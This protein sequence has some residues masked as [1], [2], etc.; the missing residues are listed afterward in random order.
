M[1]TAAIT[2]V[3]CLSFAGLIVAQ[4]KASDVFGL[5]SSTAT[6]AVSDYVTVPASIPI[7]TISPEDIE[8]DSIEFFEQ[9]YTTSATTNMFVVRWTYTEEGAKKVL[10]FRKAHDGQ[11]V[12]TRIGSFEFRGSIK[13]RDSYPPGW[14]NDERWLKRRTDKFFGVSE[15]DAKKIVDGLMK[16]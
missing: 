7:S 9:H 5:L 13:P 4:D 1:R 11:E 3:L 15:D 14:V 2:I 16:K 10:A 8:Q 12:I 6:N